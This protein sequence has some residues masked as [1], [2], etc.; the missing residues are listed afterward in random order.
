LK[1]EKHHSFHFDLMGVL[2]L[3]YVWETVEHYLELGLAGA[4]VEYW[5]QGSEFWANRIISDPLMLVLGY[6]IAKRYPKLV[7]PARVLSLLWII[8]HIFFFPHSMWLHHI[9]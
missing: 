1:R 2:F 7:N 9:F 8:V 3:A 6:L 5:F 4:K